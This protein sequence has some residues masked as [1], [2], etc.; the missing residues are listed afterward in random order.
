MWFLQVWHSVQQKQAQSNWDAGHTS[1]CLQNIT[2]E[3]QK[4]QRPAEKAFLLPFVFA[5]AMAK[6]FAWCPK[7]RIKRRSE[8]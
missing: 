4:R 5:L 7:P 1:D 8:N 6:M 2:K 3:T